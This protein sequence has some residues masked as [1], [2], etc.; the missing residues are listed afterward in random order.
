MSDAII[1]RTGAGIIER[2]DVVPSVNAPM[3]NALRAV[4]KE[5]ARLS[6]RAGGDRGLTI[7]EAGVLVSYIKTLKELRAL[8]KDLDA[9]SSVNHLTLDELRALANEVLVALAAKE[10]EVKK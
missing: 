8:Q 7:D 1:K 5:I 4:S 10:E 6:T 3:E 9:E 2:V